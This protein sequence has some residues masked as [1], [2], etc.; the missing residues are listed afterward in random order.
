MRSDNFIYHRVDACDERLSFQADSR[1]I[2]NPS[3]LVF[4]RPDQQQRIHK[5]SDAVSLR[6]VSEGRNFGWIKIAPVAQPD[7]ASDF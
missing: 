2:K 4:V 6:F 7:R 5:E 3:V 1:I